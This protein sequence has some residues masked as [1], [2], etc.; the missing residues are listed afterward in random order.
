VIGFEIIGRIE[1]VETIAVGRGVRE[2]KR[3]RKHYG[4]WRWRK[5]KGFATVL[6]EFG[7][8]RT[9]ELHWYECVGL[10]RRE[11]KLKRYLD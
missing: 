3:L 5:C 1:D 9:A 4:G 10:G 2:T 11:F 6:T 7:I 8:L